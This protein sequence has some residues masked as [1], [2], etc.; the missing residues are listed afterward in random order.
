M[1]CKIYFK[2]DKFKHNRKSPEIID[3]V[4]SDFN[5]MLGLVMGDKT[6]EMVNM[7]NFMKKS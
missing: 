7:E 4:Y 5:M 6:V 1:K 2:P 3:I